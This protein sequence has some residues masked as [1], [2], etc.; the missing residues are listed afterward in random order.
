MGNYIGLD[1]GVSG[2]IALLVP[3]LVQFQT[4]PVKTER[5][6]TKAKAQITRLDWREFDILLAAWGQYAPRIFIERPYVNPGGFKATVSALRCLESTL[7]SIE[8]FGLSYQ[9]VDSREWQREL[10]PKGLKGKDLKI[11]S[12]TIGIRLFPELSEEIRKHKDADSLLIAEWA[13]RHNL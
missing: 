6:Y 1:N 10:L 3:E 2:S 9:Y 8:R 12:M 11:A 4:V 13:R 7:V 5:S